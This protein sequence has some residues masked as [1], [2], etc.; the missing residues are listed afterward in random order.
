MR[1]TEDR[2]NA[3]RAGTGAGV[4]ESLQSCNTNLEKIQKS[5]EVSN[6][7]LNVYESKRL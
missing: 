3:L 1:R 7:L 4:L 2:P 6:F 5:L